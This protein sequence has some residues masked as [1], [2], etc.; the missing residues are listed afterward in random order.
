MGNIVGNNPEDWAKKQVDLRQQ[1][2]GLE[3]KTAE[4]LTWQTS[5]T[6][7]IRAFSSVYIE[8]GKTITEKDNEGKTIT[9][10]INISTD[11]TGNPKYRGR[12]LAKEFILFNGTSDSDW[13][14]PYTPK[15]GVANSY[16]IINNFAYGFGGTKNRGLVPMPGILSLDIS[17]YNRGSL[18]KAELKLKAYNR[19]QF[20]ILDTLY[21]R[22]GYTLLLEWGHTLYFTGKPEEFTFQK[23][24]F[25]TKPF[26]Y[27]SAANN[28]ES[29][30]PNQDDILQAIVTEREKTQGNYDGFYGK[31]TNFNWTYNTDGSYDITVSAISIGDVIES[32]KINH[33]LPTF[34]APE[35][36]KNNSSGN[37]TPAYFYFN[38]SDN[39][40]NFQYKVR[41]TEKEKYYEYW[42]MDSGGS[43]TPDG[44][45]FTGTTEIVNAYKSAKAKYSNLSSFVKP[46]L[47]RPADSLAPEP[48][49][50]NNVLI[51]QRDKTI[52]NSWIYDN[53][54]ELKNKINKEGQKIATTSSGKSL[55]N[56]YFF[57][58]KKEFLM[59]QPLTQVDVL[60]GSSGTSKGTKTILSKNAPF[61]YV[62]LGTILEYIEKQLLIVNGSGDPIL[63][64]DTNW[65]DTFCYTFPEQFSSDP[66]VCVI[67]FKTRDSKDSDKISG[68]YWENVLGT[69]FK[70]GGSDFVGKLLH[71]HV[72]MH[73][74]AGVLNQSTSNN[75]VPLL[76]FLENLLYGI[77]EALGSVN[78]FSVVYD[79]DQNTIKIFDDLPLDPR[80]AKTVVPPEQR[81]LLNVYGWKPKQQ[82][83]SFI[84]NVGISTTLSNQFATMISIGAQSRSK[85]D[86][87]NA[88][89]FSKWN[90][91]LVDII[92]P[93]KLS[94]AVSEQNQRDLKNPSQLF[95]KNIEALK[96]PGNVI[97]DFYKNG[98]TPTGEAISSTQSLNAS[99]SQYLGTVYNTDNQIP[100]IQG[101]IPFS[102][103]LDMDG[104][105]GLRIYEKFYITTEILPP[106]YPKTLSF[107][108][109]GLRH[110][111]DGSGWKTS[112]ESLTVQSSDELKPIDTPQNVIANPD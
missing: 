4:V 96:K 69:D 26:S 19:E 112:I 88:T 67:P 59:V 1:L 49:L 13:L 52:F 6:A 3:N 39:K 50:G 86:V 53:F 27:L 33:T 42:S 74:L 43:F 94:R 92:Q 91:G 2:L 103:N 106:S 85:S 66:N 79:H 17:T 15:S 12:G 34:K 57:G 40:G 48:S 37:I 87:T 65:E 111:I 83:G 62:K 36:K 51:T 77:Q 8:E 56:T 78:K 73:Y 24:Q 90:E 98:K 29:E 72:N 5:K 63:K 110:T 14:N 109:K 30:T 21:M 31:I 71:I 10:E 9:R 28:P 104:F 93:Q 97:S 25:L 108:V 55:I 70:T 101:F 102:M 44:K 20:A 18:R 7:W 82:N 45:Q 60:D 58:D 16:S 46:T 54:T 61:Q 68:T 23:A 47:K 38:L 32:L 105:S 11:L 89:A 84:T 81:T 80:V 95:A 107:L 99:Y 76:R 75:A 35:P 64:F 22:P 100:S 41:E